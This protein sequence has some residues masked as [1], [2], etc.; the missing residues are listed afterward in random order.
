MRP[1]ISGVALQAALHRS[2]SCSTATQNCL[3]CLSRSSD[4][5]RREAGHHPLSICPARYGKA[6]SSPLGLHSTHA[7]PRCPRSALISWVRC[8][9]SRSRTRKTADS[10][11][12]AR[13]GR[14]QSLG[15]CLRPSPPEPTSHPLLALPVAA[16]RRL[17]CR[18]GRVQFLRDTR[19]SAWE[20]QHDRASV[21]RHG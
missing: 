3:V 13:N 12:F 9:T 10:A 17:E 5:D 21:W 11:C 1:A 20:K 6:A 2:R 18:V 16:C 14:Q 4:Q 19:D 8:P 7:R 15:V